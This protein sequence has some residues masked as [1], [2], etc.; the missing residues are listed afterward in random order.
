M[1]ATA[2]GPRLRWGIAGYGDV[3]IRR[4]L[5]AFGSLRQ[6]IACIWGRDRSRAAAVAARHGVRRGTDSLGSLFDAVDA[7]YIATP[8]VAHVPLALAALERGLHVLVEKPLG[9][10]LGYDQARLVAA[11]DAAAVVGAVA[12][13]FRLAPALLVTRD[14]LRG[15]PYRALVQFRRAFSPAAADPMYWRT[16]VA[17]S[18]GG[19]LA[20]A[21]SHRVDLLCWLFG[22]PVQVRGTLTGRFPGGAERRATVELAWADGS[23]AQLRLDW[24]AGAERDSFACAGRDHVIRLPRLDSGQ[25]IEQNSDGVTQRRLPLPPNVLV[26]VLRDF[27]AAVDGGGRPSCSLAE[28][29]VVDDVIRAVGRV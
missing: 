25:L 18:G 8:V 1:T 26:P 10:G 4:A 21:G 23:T 11:A 29:I 24:A 16:I 15:G 14:L 17:T 9:G 3:V 13:Y 6:E 7:V 2:A 12:Y 5:P 20:D 27:L 28:A 19:V 22:P